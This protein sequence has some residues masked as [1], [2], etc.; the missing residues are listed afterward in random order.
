MRPRKGHIVAGQGDRDKRNG[1]AD[2]GEGKEFAGLYVHI[3]G[4]P[5]VAI[6][7]YKESMRFAHGK[8][9]LHLCRIAT[10]AGPDNGPK[11]AR[12]YDPRAA[13]RA[14]HRRKC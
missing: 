10:Q 4:L 13:R 2:R 11:T 8:S 14:A 9:H 7:F 3:Y 5:F 12:I 1:D 6:L